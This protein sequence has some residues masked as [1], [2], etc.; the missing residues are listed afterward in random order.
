MGGYFNHFVN[1]FYN[2]I[3]CLTLY[4]IDLDYMRVTSFFLNPRH[5][6]TVDEVSDSFF[7]SCN[8]C[9]KFC[10]KDPFFFA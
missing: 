2:V 7:L 4:K 9:T 8:F 10:K 6:A 3:E 1:N 5:L